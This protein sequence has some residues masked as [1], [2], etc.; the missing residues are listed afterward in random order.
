LIG[1][2][3]RWAVVSLPINL[4]DA[5]RYALTSGQH[6]RTDFFAIVK[7]KDKIRQLGMR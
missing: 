5:I 2:F 3:A 7:R 1:A 4:L 6:A